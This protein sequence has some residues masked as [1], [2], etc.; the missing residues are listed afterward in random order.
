MNVEPSLS[1]LQ[2][3]SI[4]STCRLTESSCGVISRRRTLWGIVHGGGD[5]RSAGRVHFRKITFYE[6]SD[7]FSYSLWTLAAERFCGYDKFLLAGLLALVGGGG[8]G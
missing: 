4:R 3:L 5:C 7:K 2:E 6:R 1:T 8:G